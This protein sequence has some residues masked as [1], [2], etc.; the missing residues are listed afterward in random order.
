MWTS[1]PL[2]PWVKQSYQRKFKDVLSAISWFWKENPKHMFLWC[3][4]GLCT[5]LW[6]G[7]FLHPDKRRGFKPRGADLLS[8]SSVRVRPNV[9]QLVHQM[10][11]ISCRAHD[12]VQ[13]YLFK[14][15][16]AAVCGDWKS[17]YA[18]RKLPKQTEKCVKSEKAPS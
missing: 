1:N 3:C 14:A 16:V 12:Q 15:N 5:F 8:V 7:L 6:T 17:P 11:F 18:F 4:L 2:S 13:R 10:Y 9:G